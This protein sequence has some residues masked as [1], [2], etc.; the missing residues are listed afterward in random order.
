LK[1]IKVFG[2]KL[3]LLFLKKIKVFLNCV[4]VHDLFVEVFVKK[5]QSHFYLSSD[6]L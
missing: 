3:K 1:K 6:I 2:K 4:F 5:I